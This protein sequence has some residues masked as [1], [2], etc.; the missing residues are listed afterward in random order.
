MRD[1]DNILTGEEIKNA[2]VDS[3]VRRAQFI[4]TV[5]KKIG[6]RAPKLVTHQFELAKVRDAF[7]QSLGRNLLQP[8]EYRNLASFFIENQLHPR[9]GSC[10]HICE[11]QSM[12]DPR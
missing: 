2:I 3:P 1:H 8:F 9:H 7:V 5:S 11:H 12:K 4:N 10:S 6:K